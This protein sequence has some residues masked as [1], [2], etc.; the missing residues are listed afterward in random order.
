[1]KKIISVLLCICTLF[2]TACG[3]S[4][5]ISQEEYNKVVAERD[6][7]TE[8]ISNLESALSN[9]TV[10]EEGELSQE[11][12]EQPTENQASS[13]TRESEDCGVEIL[14]EYTLADGIGWYTRH[15][16]VI[17]NNTSETVDV[18]T[19]SLAYA[20]DGTMVGADDADFDA[21]GA[22]CTS[23]MYEAF[24]VDSEIDYYETE[25][26]VSKCKYYDSAIQDLSYVQ[27]DIEGGAV[28]QVTNN[29][30]KAA[31]FVKGYALFFKGDELVEYE[32]VYFTDDDSELKPG[33]TISKQMKS[34]AE[35]DR[36]E[37]YMTGRR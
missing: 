33:K 35:F 24:E 12:S 15:F 16:I 34:Y 30:E 17:K 11:S 28:F 26:S 37:F 9:L 19:S 3:S 22:G 23:V 6:E 21:L 27:N 13:D 7:L 14:A 2:M 20:K 32:D 31:E 29:G 8:R 4:N 36:I 18:S 25:L 10:N 5:G 1:M